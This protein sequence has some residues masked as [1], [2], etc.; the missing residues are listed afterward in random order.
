MKIYIYTLKHP[1]TQEVRYV[2]K[3]KRPKRRLSEHTYQRL[4]ETKK[5]HLAYWLLSLLKE[6][7][8]PIMEIVAETED[9]WESLEQEWIKKFSNLCNHT[10]GGEGCHGYKQPEA[11]L[12]KRRQA[13]LGKNVGKKLSD[14]HKEAI[15][16]FQSATKKDKPWKYTIEQVKAVKKALL[17]NSCKACIARE[18]N[19][20]TNFVYE[21]SYGRYSEVE[22]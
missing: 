4:L 6:G 20:N 22:I 3:S 19:V 13:M 14:K 10:E 12:Q 16:K 17:T 1:D 8:K 2:G 11:H 9:D 7:K 18:L 15:A 5:T 21:I